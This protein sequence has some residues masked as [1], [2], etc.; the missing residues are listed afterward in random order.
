MS[1]VTPFLGLHIRGPVA[2][3][4]AAN[5]G[6]ASQW[7][8]DA[9]AEILDAAIESISGPVSGKADL[10]N[11]VLK[12]SQFPGLTGDVV[13]NSGG[14]VTYLSAIGAGV[15]MADHQAGADWGAK[16][17]AADTL[18]G[19]TPG[20][21]W[22]TQSAGTTA[23]AANIT[24]NSGH[25]LR[26]LQGGTWALGTKSLI[27]PVGA[28]K[29]AVVGSPAYQSKLTYSGSDYAVV[30]G[31]AAGT[32]TNQI[33]FQDIY[34][35]PQSTSALGAFHL[36]NTVTLKMVRVQISANSLAQ[37]YGV[38]SDGT[39]NFCAFTSLIDCSFV[40]CFFG[41]TFTGT[42]NAANNANLMMGCAFDGISKATV[43]S[44]GL[45]VKG[46]SNN[47][48]SCDFNGW[49]SGI[50]IRAP[51]NL[52]NCVR[53]EGATVATHVTFTSAAIGNKV[54][55]IN[56]ASGFVISDS[57]TS[58]QVFF[59]DQNIALLDSPLFT[60][61][62]TLQKNA[63]GSS[64][65][66]VA[67]AI[68]QNTTAAANNA[69]QDPPALEMDGKYWDGSASQTGSIVFAP[70]FG[71]GNPPTM[72]FTFLMKAAA[73]VGYNVI[74][75]NNTTSTVSQSGA[76]PAFAFVGSYWNGSQSL[77]ETWEFVADL[78]N[79]TNPLSRFSILHFG[80]AGQAILDLNNES[81]R[82]GTAF[83]IKIPT[84][85]AND[86]SSNAASTQY[87][88]TAQALDE[89][90]A[91]KD[92]ASGYAGL[93]STTFVK[94]PE[95]PP[96]L[97][98]GVNNSVTA[99]PVDASGNPNYASTATA[100]N[101]ATLT[102]NG[103]VTPLEMYI[104]GQYQRVVNQL[105]TVVLNNGGASAPKANFVYLKKKSG[106]I[107]LTSA[108]IGVTT[109]AFV[110]G[111]NQTA[112]STTLA[113]SGNPVYWFDP[114][115]GKWK[116]ATSNGGSFTADPIIPLCIAV[117]DST[118]A[119]VGT[120]YW[121]PRWTPWKVMEYCGQGTDGALNVQTGTTTIQ[122]QKQYTS[123]VV[124]GGTLT[125]GGFSTNEIPP[126]VNCQGPIIVCNSG[127]IHAN[128]V[129]VIGGAASGTTVGANANASTIMGS[130]GGGGGGASAGVGGNATTRQAL[131]AIGAA[132]STNGLGG[133]GGTLVLTSVAVVGAVT[134]YNG[135][136]TNGA[137]ANLVGR[138]AVI[139]GFTNGNNNGSFV[140]TAATATT[141]VVT[142]VSQANETHA[143]TAV[144]NCAGAQGTD[145]GTNAPSLVGIC[146]LGWAGG[147]GGGGGADGGAGSGGAGGAGGGCFYIIG[148]VGLVI[149]SGCTF[150][151]NGVNGSAGGGTNG[152][153][154]GGGG[155]GTLTALVGYYSNAGTVTATGGSSGAAA[156]T[157]SAGAAGKNGL[158]QI[159]RIF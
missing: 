127:V 139:A 104:D 140:I 97:I 6:S 132:T 142:T 57:G 63:I 82:G 51:R 76:P 116:K 32:L 143:G 35:A 61:L 71:S 8:V 126:C 29:V 159:Q 31:S 92:A 75:K 52:M 48:I 124:S 148:A 36:M 122:G 107:N 131:V 77:Q 66:P 64:A 40:N 79:G 4:N 134:T 7:D 81:G 30:V 73:S 54:Y 86:N 60:T 23:P 17:Q 65:T 95:L 74:F 158:I 157:G 80:S 47:V 98:E 42:S 146:A 3:E 11:G 109:N 147:G 33:L 120:G 93:D 12:T 129:G 44:I 21:I 26:F 19:A 149:S 137:N 34:I 67:G 135:T 89:K 88:D 155:G 58:N 87:V 55:T 144:V 59:T 69:Q 9:N 151:A 50:I 125:T 22:I 38:L 10:V 18:L 112:P 5:G 62:L 96:W 128:A 123:L 15:V 141:I 108:E 117:V 43:G 68:L 14:L 121:G 154:G 111:N 56:S 46:D 99:G 2:T 41:A 84:A 70:H 102:V 133:V 106:T 114:T 119:Q 90:L 153:G 20:E 25:V 13:A 28:L 16:V 110:F 83:T 85:A 115:V 24:L 45:D 118:G 105:L 72:N 53:F 94:C 145:A 91:N 136:I 103:N 100:I 49:E 156:G 1:D 113:T 39:G 27:I 150:S 130:A 78:A 152:A 37:Q 101:V 138:T